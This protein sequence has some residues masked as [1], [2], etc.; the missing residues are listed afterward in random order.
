MCNF[1][2]NATKNQK[3][4]QNNLRI[5]RVA[6]CRIRR[7]RYT[8]PP[9]PPK[10]SLPAWCQ[11]P[12]LTYGSLGPPDRWLQT[13]SRSSQLL[14]G[15]IP[16]GHSDPLCHALLLSLSS[17]LSSSSLS[18]WT[19][20]AAC[21]IAIA[22]VRLATSGDWQCNG[23]S[24]LANGPNIFQML[25]VLENS[26]SLLKNRPTDRQN[27]HGTRPVSTATPFVRRR[28]NSWLTASL[29]WRLPNMCRR[30][31]KARVYS[32]RWWFHN[33][34]R[35]I[36]VNSDRCS[37][38]RRCCC[39][40][41]RYDTACSWRRSSGLKHTHTHAYLNIISTGDIQPK[42]NP[43][44]NPIR[45][46]RS[47]QATPSDLG[48]PE[49]NPILTQ[50][51]RHIW[52]IY[53]YGI[54]QTGGMSLICRLKSP[55]VSPVDMQFTY[56]TNTHT[57]VT[58]VSRN[59]FTTSCRLSVQYTDNAGFTSINNISVSF[60]ISLSLFFVSMTD[61]SRQLEL[62][63]ST[64]LKW[65]AKFK[66]NQHIHSNFD[67]AKIVERIWGAERWASL[68]IVRLSL[69]ISSWCVLLVRPHKVSYNVSMRMWDW[70]KRTSPKWLI[71]CRVA[72]RT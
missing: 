69:G 16:Y 9:F 72:R 42:T 24:H 36:Q 63:G 11:N 19:S 27:G 40:S 28:I 67:S 17:S 44:P 70:L 1:A 37:C 7:T 64:S 61:T 35:W 4:V 30:S 55:Y 25:L 57:S 2:S 59:W 47:T 54:L 33:Y 38:P 26:R 5:G 29:E 71:V 62:P 48:I 56:T 6:Q 34:C 41:R 60:N 3:I 58:E 66:K 39:T 10:L 32:R 18:L 12:R 51:W 14:F 52:G 15:S 22:G 68:W 49:H 20:H 13:A 45:H 43:N 65:F 46:P 21:A 53:K 50:L 23:G 31:D 8:A